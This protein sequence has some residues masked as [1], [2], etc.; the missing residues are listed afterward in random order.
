MKNKSYPTRL[1]VC[2]RTRQW[3]ER[4]F[5]FSLVLCVLLLRAWWQN[6]KEAAYCI[7][8]SLELFK[9]HTA[10]QL[11]VNAII[12]LVFLFADTTL[13]FNTFFSSFFSRERK[14]AAQQ[15]SEFGGPSL[16]ARACAVAAN[17]KTNSSGN[18]REFSPVFGCKVSGQL[19]YPCKQERP[20]WEAAVLR[21]LQSTWIFRAMLHLPCWY[22]R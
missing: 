14:L 8:S 22:F 5:I 21:L 19:N 15:S 9:E 10:P 1:L 16:W 20:R 4:E 6:T 7:I 3:A 18:L 13:T 11:H 12:I 2:S 17:S